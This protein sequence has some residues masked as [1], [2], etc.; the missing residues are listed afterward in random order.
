[1]MQNKRLFGYLSLVCLL[2]SP[3]SAKEIRVSSASLRPVGLLDGSHAHSRRRVARA[4]RRSFFHLL[5]RKGRGVLSRARD[6]SGVRAVK[7]R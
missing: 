6:Y 5:K 1:M 3:V 7:V 2:L 4:C